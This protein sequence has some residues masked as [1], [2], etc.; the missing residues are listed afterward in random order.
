MRCTTLRSTERSATINRYARITGDAI[1]YAAG[2]L[3]RER[4]RLGREGLRAVIERFV[5]EQATPPAGA[6]DAR[7]H[8]VR[9]PNVRRI[10]DGLLEAVEEMRHGL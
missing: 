1:S 5:G 7:K 10:F 2:R 8:P 6:P 4:G 3:T 9:C